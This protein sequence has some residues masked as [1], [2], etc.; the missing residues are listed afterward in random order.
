MSSNF[1][2]VFLRFL[3][4]F[5]KIFFVEKKKKHVLAC[6]YFLQPLQFLQSPEQ[7]ELC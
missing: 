4:F 2:S 5:K 1:E 6:F 7:A 3:K